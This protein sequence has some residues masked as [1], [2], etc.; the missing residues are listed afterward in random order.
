MNRKL[1]FLLFFLLIL[2]MDLYAWRGLRHLFALQMKGTMVFNIVYW[3][4]TLLMLAALAWT[5]TV[6]RHHR[7]PSLFYRVTLVLGIF[8]MLFVPKL[9]FNAFQLLGDLTLGV[10]RLVDRE[11]DFPMIRKFF[12]IPGS[13]AGVLLMTGFATGMAVGKTNLKVFRKEI[14][15]PGLPEPFS[16]TRIVQISDF[17]LAGFHNNPE[18]IKKV[19]EQVNRLEPDM[20]VFTGDMVHNFSEEMDPFM[21]ILKGLKAPLGKYAILGNHD[22]GRYFRWNSRE[23]EAANLEKVKSQIRAAGFDLLLNEHR[24][25][26]LNGQAIELVG[27]ESWGKP[28]FPKEGDLDRALSGTD[29]SRVKILLSHDPSHWDLKVRG[30]ENIPLTLSG[31]THGFQVGFEIGKFRWSPSRWAYPHWAGLYHENGQYLYVNRGVGFTGFPGRVGIR[32]EITLLTLVR[33][34]P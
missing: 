23:E 10:T 7:D 16:G 21:D 24:T 29:P 18:H 19:V 1:I 28:P 11:A 26:P 3:G 32:P 31:H 15:I 9:L 12:L 4:L 6:F 14:G 20:I 33:D 13:I 5:G 17:H 8:L 22:Y 30:K 34:Q 2:A 25:I 27:V